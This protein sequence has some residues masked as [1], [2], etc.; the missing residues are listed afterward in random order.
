MANMFL[1]TCQRPC[2][3]WKSRSRV[4]QH[5]ETRCFPDSVHSFFLRLSKLAQLVLMTN[6]PLLLCF[7]LG[8][9]VLTIWLCV[10]HLWAAG[11][12]E[13]HAFCL[14]LEKGNKITPQ[15]SLC[16]N[17]EDFIFNAIVI[18]LGNAFA[19]QKTCSATE[20]VTVSSTQTHSL[21]STDVHTELIKCNHSLGHSAHTLTPTNPISC[22][23]FMHSYEFL[24]FWV[25]AK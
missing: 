9:Q 6:S 20:A 10:S 17:N 11:L 8:G 25:S 22:M 23:L 3:I 21:Y 13:R 4:P 18:Q 24:F 1:F 5:R 12:W 19:L 15:S 14:R 2:N 7:L 16:V